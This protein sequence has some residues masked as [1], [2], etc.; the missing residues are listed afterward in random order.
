M[1][2]LTETAI[3]GINIAAGVAYLGLVVRPR[4]MR[5]DTCAKIVPAANA[6]EW[7]ALR[8][9]GQR[10]VAEATAHCVTEVVFV[11]PRRRPRGWPYEE[12]HTRAALH[13]AA[14]L[15]LDSAGI[16]ARSIS[17]KTIASG[18]R[19]KGEKTMD[20][21]LPELLGL[22]PESVVHWKE[23]RIAIAAAIHVARGTH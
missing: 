19:C 14:G 11:E 5:L 13:T 1:S 15:A 7:V 20:A 21:K 22:S 4:Q 8:D 16:A 9:F 6:G 17:Q 2:E 23:R 12:A 3:L 10:L 18:F